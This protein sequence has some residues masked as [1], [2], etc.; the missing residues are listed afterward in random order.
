MK[1]R[2]VGWLI[3]LAIIAMI[4]ALKLAWEGYLFTATVLVLIVLAL[5]FTGIVSLLRGKDW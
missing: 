5:S 3:V 4:V 1:F 2:T